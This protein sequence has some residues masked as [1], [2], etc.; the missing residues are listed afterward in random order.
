M[1][2]VTNLGAPTDDPR[3]SYSTQPSWERLVPGCCNHGFDRDWMLLSVVDGCGFLCELNLNLATKQWQAV[4]RFHGTLCLLVAD[5]IGKTKTGPHM[6][7]RCGDGANVVAYE[8]V[9]LQ[10]RNV[11]SWVHIQM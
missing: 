2:V 9:C 4:H 5:E 1:I 11:V 7:Y 3:V 10:C 6:L 8:E